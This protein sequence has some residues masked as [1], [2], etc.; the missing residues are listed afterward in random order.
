V[1]ERGGKQR[2]NYSNIVVKVGG[3]FCVITP[4]YMKIYRGQ[5]IQPWTFVENQGL[6]P[7]V[8]RHFYHT[9]HSFR[10]LLPPNERHYV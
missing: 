2:G 9:S 4:S 8:W 5:M 1:A 7:L 6:K 10:L 3:F